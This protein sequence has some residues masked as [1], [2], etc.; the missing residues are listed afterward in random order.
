MSVHSV[1][2]DVRHVSHSPGNSL[3]NSGLADRL[4]YL[5]RKLE[6]TTSVLNDARVALREI[7]STNRAGTIPSKISNG[8]DLWL[9]RSPNASIS[10]LFNVPTSQKFST[11]VQPTKPSR[12]CMDLLEMEGVIRYHLNEQA[13]QPPEKRV[14]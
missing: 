12:F 13:S 9:T 11:S 5:E 14:S 1:P 3:E 10:P 8:K 7:N 6:E 2:G 4:V